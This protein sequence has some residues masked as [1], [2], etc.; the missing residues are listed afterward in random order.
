MGSCCSA[1]ALFTFHIY[2]GIFLAQGGSLPRLEWE[3]ILVLQQK[4]LKSLNLN[5]A[6]DIAPPLSSFATVG[7]V[8]QAWCWVS[9]L[10]P[11]L[12]VMK[13]LDFCTLCVYL[14]NKIVEWSCLGPQHMFRAYGPSSWQENSDVTPSCHI[15]SLICLECWHNKRR[16]CCGSCIWVF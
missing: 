14:V 12:F 15:L 11:W 6:L 7:Q 4:R 2:L 16:L 5:Q 8:M 1:V 9:R 10:S 3:T 13:R